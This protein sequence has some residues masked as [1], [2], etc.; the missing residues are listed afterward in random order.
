[1]NTRKIRRIITLLVLSSTLLAMGCAGQANTPKSSA[2]S[3]KPKTYSSYPPMTIDQNK[4]YTATIQTEKGN[5]VI[6]L[7][8]GDVPKAVNNFVFLAREGFY[9]TTFHRVLAGFMAQAGDPTGTGSGGPGY[10]WVRD[11]PAQARRRSVSM[12][13]SSLPDSNGSQF[14]ICYSAQPH[15]DGGYSVSDSLFRVWIY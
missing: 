10:N 9:D 13:H 3:P 7:F 8:A 4:K 15:L 1:M 11:N 2:N 5:L 6:E 12:A 14:F